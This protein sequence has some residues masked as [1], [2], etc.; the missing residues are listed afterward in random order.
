MVIKIKV[1]ATL[2]GMEHGWDL[3]KQAQY[4]NEKRQQIK[5]RLSKLGAECVNCE[6]DEMTVS[7]SDGRGM[8]GS[9]RASVRQACGVYGEAFTNA[10]YI[11]VI[12]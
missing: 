5:E 11:R 12:A 10:G 1:N 7:R 9:C 3:N 2:E 6:W 4:A 8:V